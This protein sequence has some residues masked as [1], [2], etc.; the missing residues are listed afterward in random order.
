[1]RTNVFAIVVGGIAV[2]VVVFLVALFAGYGKTSW[3][4]FQ[5]TGKES[6]STSDGNGNNGHEYRLYTTHGTYKVTDSVIHWRRNS[7][8][9]YGRLLVGHKYHCKVYGWRVPLVSS[10]KNVLDCKQIG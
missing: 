7:A 4:D 8:D 3:V 9:V 6:V 1:M 10:F 2:V 5:L